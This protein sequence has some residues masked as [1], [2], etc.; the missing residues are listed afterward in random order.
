MNN[1]KLKTNILKPVYRERGPVKSRLKY[2]RLD[3][4]ERISNFEKEIF[5]NIV[6]KF[7]SEYLTAYPEL[8]KI[9]TLIAKRN[10]IS[11]NNL[12]ITAGSDGAIR[13]CFDLFTK[14]ND[15]IICLSPTF[16]MVDVYSRTHKLK[17][18]KIKYDTNLNL[19][20][21]SILKRLLKM[22]H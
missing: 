13:M 20:L 4:N 3:K 8:E 5:K 14:N 17:Q 6:K 9:Y 12:V 19:D 2:L 11:K 7:K 18:I 16:A 21:K 1:F 15:Q 10:K 22:L